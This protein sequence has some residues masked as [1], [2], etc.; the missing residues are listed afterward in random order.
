[1]PSWHAAPTPPSPTTTLIAS[2]APPPPPSSTLPD[3]F[4]TVAV[5]LAAAMARGNLTLLQATAITYRR[6]ATYNRLSLAS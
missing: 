2:A 3:G 4:L 6:G 1:M 5:P